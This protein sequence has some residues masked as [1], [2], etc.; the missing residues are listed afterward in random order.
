MK[1][2]RPINTHGKPARI[3]Q[4][5][6]PGRHLGIDYG[7]VKGTPVYASQD[8]TVV[9]RNATEK[10]WWRANTSNDPYRLAN[11]KARKLITADYGQFVKLQHLE[12]YQTLYAHMSKV[13]VVNGQR[14]RKGEKIGEVGATGNTGGGSHL[15]HE[16]R[17]VYWGIRTVFLNLAQ[18]IDSSFKDYR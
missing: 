15:H 9:L 5:F 4:A 13:T 6:I 14:V 3:T 12:G 1:F 2:V 18:Y 11:G 8:G 17:K 10:R 16:L 7:Y